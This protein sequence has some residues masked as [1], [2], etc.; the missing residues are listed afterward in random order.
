MGSQSHCFLF[1][2]ESPT[3]NELNFIV[4]NRCTRHIVGA[5]L[6]HAVHDEHSV[7][8]RTIC[9]LDNK[10]Y[11]STCAAKITFTS[12]GT[13]HQVTLLDVTIIPEVSESFISVS[14]LAQKDGSTCFMKTG[15]QL[16]YNDELIAIGT[17]V[18]NLYCIN[19][20]LPDGRLLADQSPAPPLSSSSSS[21]SLSSSSWLSTSYSHPRSSRFSSIMDLHHS[22]GHANPRQLIY[23]M[24]SDSIQ[25]VSLN[26]I[27]QMIEKCD[28]CAQAKMKTLKKNGSKPLSATYPM[29][30][31][32]TDYAGPFSPTLAGHRGFQATIDVCS[33]RVFSDL[34]KTQTENSDNLAD[35]VVAGENFTRNSVKTICTDGAREYTHTF[36]KFAVKK[37]IQLQH[38]SPHCQSQNGLAE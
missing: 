13:K 30:S 23:A 19:I 26:D 31:L 36:K 33:R 22:L 12:T 29:E 27:E 3:S 17:K 15:C 5:N 18:Q 2:G 9:L 1:S 14:Q 37:D 28:A 34:S 11:T 35:L 20:S 25:G 24:E 8:P 38:S 4:D 10:R 6:L 16:Y 21:S 32:Q 7:C